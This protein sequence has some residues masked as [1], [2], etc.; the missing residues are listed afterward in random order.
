[1]VVGI[2]VGSTSPCHACIHIVGGE[3]SWR[4]MF[5]DV[6]GDTFFNSVTFYG[7]DLYALREDGGFD[8]FR[9]MGRENHAWWRDVAKAPASCCTSVP[10]CFQLRCDQHILRV[11]VGTFGES[12]ENMAPK[13]ATRSTRVPPVTP[14]P[15]AQPQ[16]L[17]RQQLHLNIIKDF[18]AAMALRES[19]DSLDGSRKWN[20]CLALAIAQQLAKSNS[21]LALCKTMLLHGGI[22]MLRPP[23][24]RSSIIHHASTEKMRLKILPEGGEYKKIETES[25]T[26]RQWGQMPYVR[27]KASSSKC[28]GH[29]EAG[30]LS[31]LECKVVHAPILHYQKKQDFIHTATAQR[32]IGRLLVRLKLEALSVRELRGTV[33]QLIIKLTTLLIQRTEQNN[34]DDEART[35]KTS[36]EDVGGVVPCDDDL[37]LSDHARVPKIENGHADEP[38]TFRWMDFILRQAS[39]FEAPIEITD[40]EVKWLK[41][42]R[43]HSQ[44]S[45]DRQEWSS[46]TWNARS[47]PE[48]IPTFVRKEWPS[49]SGCV[50]SL[51]D[52]AH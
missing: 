25:G 18:A 31:T 7:R 47:I 8:V 32:R 10:Q 39:V 21:R 51:E 45:M 46:F 44:G 48:E 52:K 36:N 26:L 2:T 24:P 16:L 6:W 37:R 13:R 9:E 33:I 28:N 34:A 5:L 35:Q 29:H 49:S 4:R 40:R 23:I 17:L 3:P 41:R 12:V 15:N 11:I 38:V 50:L 14:A 42:S 20:L 19:S 43:N 27:V 1:M 22:P 30:L